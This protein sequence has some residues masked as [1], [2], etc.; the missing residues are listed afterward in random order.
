MK[1]KYYIPIS[2]FIISQGVYDSF[3]PFQS[4]NWSIFYFSAMYLSWL[5][6]L[7]ILPNSTIYYK[8][9]PKFVLASGLII[10]IGIELSKIG[11]D[12]ESYYR[13]VNS[14]QTNLLP[15]MVIIAGLTYF[16]LKKWQR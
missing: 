9:I 4:T 15:V 6:L 7:I 16:I 12:Y 2:F 13:S 14:F 8:N 11:M 5:I 10:Y 1:G 3:A